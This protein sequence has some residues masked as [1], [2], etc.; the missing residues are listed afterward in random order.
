MQ[1]D[2]LQPFFALGPDNFAVYNDVHVVF[3]LLVSASLAQVHSAHGRL[4]ENPGRF[5]H[6]LSTLL[7]FARTKPVG[8]RLQNEENRHHQKYLQH[9][10]SQPKIKRRPPEV[11]CG[12]V[13]SDRRMPFPIVPKHFWHQ[14]CDHKNSCAA[15]PPPSHIQPACTPFLHCVSKRLVSPSFR[16]SVSPE[17]S[18]LQSPLFCIAN[19]CK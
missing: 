18:S 1:A 5:C 2:V 6:V 14:R 17:V 4:P 19:H 15:Q 10:P 16:Q 8:P 7:R 12:W 11:R 13:G 9:N 3:P